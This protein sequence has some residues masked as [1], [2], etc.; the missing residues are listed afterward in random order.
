MNNNRIKRITGV[1][2]LI[3]IEAILQII[4]NYVTIFNAVSLNLSLIAV[5]LGAIIFGPLAGALLGLVNGVLCI[6][7]P[8]TQVLFLDVAPLA[9]ILTCLSKCTIAGL[10]SGFLF[11]LISKKNKTVASIVAALCV[12]ILNSG[13]F[14]LCAFTIL[15]KAIEM[16]NSENVDAMKFV[17]L[18]VIGWNFLFEF[19]VTSLLTPT[20]DKIRKIVVRKDRHAL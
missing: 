16:M 1:G 19:L 20:I 5:A 4:S 6:F 3:A 13:I 18:T 9:T 15:S 12:P 7:A 17:F 10:V 8:S 14:A 2:V 11:E